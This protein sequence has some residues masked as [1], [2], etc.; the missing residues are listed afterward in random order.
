MNI[1]S[2]L[3]VLAA[4]LLGAILMLGSEHHGLVTLGGLPVPGA[5]VT[6][7]QGEKK[8]TAVTDGMGSYSFPDLADGTWN[9]Q[10]EMSGFSTLK[11]DVTV[12]PAAPGQ[13]AGTSWELKIKT[14]AE[15]QAAV[16][17]PLLEARPAPPS[18]T[19][20]TARP[21]ASNGKAAAAKGKQ[22][23]T[24]QAQAGAP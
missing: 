12:G 3:R 8:V 14:L 17:A 6:A 5:I 7:T 2:Y 18:A 4:V 23:A 20:N 19:A 1:S 22:A 10:V 11:Q 13:T 15:M 16:Q 9:V 21:S 24:V